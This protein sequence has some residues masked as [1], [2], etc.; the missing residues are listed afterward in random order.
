LGFELTSGYGVHVR[1]MLARATA[2]GMP[3]DLSHVTTRP[4]DNRL[5]YDAG[6]LRQYVVNGPLGIEQRF[7]IRRV[8][9][10]VAN[11]VQLVIDVGGARAVLS[12]DGRSALL[13]TGNGSALRYAG[14]Q[15][16]DARGRRLPAHMR[17]RQSRLVLEVQSRGARFP[18]TVD[19]LLSPYAMLTGPSGPTSDFGSS[20]ALSADGNTAVIG[21]ESDAGGLGAVWVFARSGATWAQQGPKLTPTSPRALSTFG[22]KNFGSV[23]AI[24]GNGDTIGVGD[25][26]FGGALS[27]WVFVRSN[28]VWRQDGAPLSRRIPRGESP[29][30]SEVVAIS[31]D[32][33]TALFGGSVSNRPFTWVYVRAHGAWRQQG[34]PIEALGGNAALSSNGNTLLLASTEGEAGYAHI[35]V[36]SGGRWRGRG[37]TLPGSSAAGF[38]SSA[39]LAPDGRTA[40]VGNGF[41]G[42]AIVFARTGAR[43]VQIARLTSPHPEP[44]V[45][46]GSPVS[47]SRDGSMVVVGAP[48]AYQAPRG[49]TGADYV[50]T[51]Q[52]GNSWSPT[53]TLAGLPGRAAL[54]GDGSTIVAPPLLRE[55]GERVESSGKPAQVFTRSGN[56]W[57]QQATLAPRD[58]A[59]VDSKSFG[60]N[61]VLSADGATAVVSEGP[62][63][64]WAFTRSGESWSTQARLH[65][66]ATTGEGSLLALSSDGNTAVLAG[67]S[68]PGPVAAWVFTRSGGTWSADDT[69]LVAS[70]AGPRP[71]GSTEEQ[72]SFA[73]S[74][75]ISAN[76]SVIL[77]GA[78]W[79]AGH[80]GAV[81]TFTRSGSGWTQQGAKLTPS[82]ASSEE[83]FGDS[84]S[85]SADGEVA[86]VGAVGD[87][88]RPS[89]GSGPDGA[90]FVFA[91]SGASWVQTA[92]LTDS[93]GEPGWGLGSTVALSADAS[94]ALLGA[95]EHAIV[96]TKGPAGWQQH[97][98][99][100]TASPTEH[101]AGGR[102]RNPFGSVVALSGDGTRAVFGGGYDSMSCG[103]YMMNSCTGTGTVWAFSR[104]GEAWVREPLPLVSSL[105]FGHSVAIAENG[106]TV[107][108]QGQTRGPEPG[109][110][111]YVSRLTPPPQSGFVVEPPDLEY[112]GAFELVLWTPTPATFRATAHVI[113]PTAGLSPGCTHPPHGRRR[114][115]SSAPPVYGAGR[116]TGVESLGLRIAPRL[117]IGR[118]LARHGHLHLAITITARPSPPAVPSTQTVPLTIT[119]E[120]QPS[121]EE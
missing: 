52:G 98:P 112:E 121:G 63:T 26:R 74:V 58:A 50:F 67:P 109:G 46:F 43:W 27:A 54:S 95:H 108:M 40:I 48:P 86:L 8:P 31:G 88:Q 34:R 19:P 18:I 37:G 89:N 71:P 78:D 81:W 41:H 38:G 96:F 110:A 117:A 35:F 113:S 13:V 51:R 94:T 61:L 72:E 77:V 104:V 1:L 59:G 107:L 62:G 29:S 30:G 68:A 10:A 17:L 3:F 116:A 80:V 83:R 55:V 101:N 45:D 7:S 111:A 9:V 24:S 85:L 53:S 69:P 12:P 91:R 64:A 66:E 103:K 60:G 2:G 79:D 28:G 99:S 44:Q 14:L 4:D 5:V 92:K 70:G 100:L 93:E 16:S 97:R 42:Y 65:V 23:V 115:C 15:A 22:I 84:V 82:N 119:Y 120:K 11:R 6:A 33:R 25:G 49:V 56:S 87:M 57:Q 21:G 47:I 90:G 36:R 76:G 39:A 118:Y 32:G 114:H 102:S 75:A 20:V 105:P 106:E 73:S